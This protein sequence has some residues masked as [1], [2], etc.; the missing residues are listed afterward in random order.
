MKQIISASRRTDLVA[1]YP[2]WLAKAL[3]R[4]EACFFHHGKRTEIRVDLRPDRVHTLVFWSKNFQALLENRFGLGDLVKKYSQAYFHFT[5]TGLGGTFLESLAPSVSAALGQLEPL[6]E[7]AG[8]PERVSIR[9]DPIIFWYEGDELK[10]NLDFFKE[11]GPEISRRGIRTVRFS[12]AQW[13]KKSVARARRASLKFYDPDYWG[14]MEAVKRLTEIADKYDLQLW[15]CSQKEIA[16]LPG[17]K[18]SACI[19]GA[20]LSKLHPCREPASV[21]K[22]KTQRKD[23]LCTEST[24]IGSYTQSCPAACL[25]CYANPK[26]K[27]DIYP[28]DKS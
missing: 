22:D 26:I 13:Y 16:C 6:L 1:F 21:I 2:E 12:F 23:C 28:S 24:D 20:W 17:I 27:T 18:A 3:E 10:T 19:D 5:I 8:R 15:S 25:Y 7:I 9:F 11:L 14:K 4:E